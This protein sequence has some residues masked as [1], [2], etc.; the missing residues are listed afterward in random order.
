MDNYLVLNSLKGRPS[1]IDVRDQAALESALYHLPTVFS[2]KTLPAVIVSF[3]AI[4]IR[5]SSALLSSPT[6]Q[7]TSSEIS[8]ISELVR[9]LTSKINKTVEYIRP[10]LNRDDILGR[11]PVKNV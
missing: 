11:I 5:D 8:E 7:L 9:I 10:R 6:L 2:D 1:L 4:C 3:A